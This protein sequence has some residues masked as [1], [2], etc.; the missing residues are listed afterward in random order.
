[1]QTKKTSELIE[2][3]YWTCAIEGHRH[4][5]KAVAEACIEKSQS[6]KHERRVWTRS[7]RAD[8][9]ESVIKGSTLTDAGARFGV[10]GHRASQVIR[11]TIRMLLHPNYRTDESFEFPE[12]DMYSLEGIR[13]IGNY[14][15]RQ[16][17]RL[18]NE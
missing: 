7:M 14:W 5:T 10:S 4:K 18:R 9:F 15:L 12:R 13:E 1:M 2:V 16:I 6:P 17:D 3:F 11:K 8:L